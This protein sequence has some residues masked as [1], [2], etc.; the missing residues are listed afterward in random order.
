MVRVPDQGRT[1]PE[2]I[3]FSLDP[4]RTVKYDH[5][6]NRFPNEAGW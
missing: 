2:A 6:G 1:R 3:G 4:L 5:D